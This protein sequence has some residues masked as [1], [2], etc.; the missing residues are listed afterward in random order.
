MLFFN[1]FSF[2]VEDH[3]QN[4]Y[5]LGDGL[6]C[7]TYKDPSPLSSSKHIF[8]KCLSL[9]FNIILSHHL[10]VS[11]TSINESFFFLFSNFPY[12][13]FTVNKR[14]NKIMKNVKR[15]NSSI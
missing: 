10:S 14:P 6:K 4:L 1:N 12:H 5:L 13:E 2:Q 8:F 7:E 3:F 15:T 11:F 9:Q